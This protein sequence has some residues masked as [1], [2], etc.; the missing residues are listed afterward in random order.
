MLKSALIENYF[1][2][3]Q[4]RKLLRIELRIRRI[5][6]ANYRETNV[7]VNGKL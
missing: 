7:M 6:C 1:D 4:C 2:R 3:W 5:Y